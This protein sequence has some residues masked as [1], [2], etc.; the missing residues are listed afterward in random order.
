VEG[1]LRWF[2]DL[3]RCHSGSWDHPFPFVCCEDASEVRKEGGPKQAG[4]G[5]SPTPFLEALRKER[6]FVNAAPSFSPPN[7]SSWVHMFE[8]HDP[9]EGLQFDR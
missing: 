8:P 3:S 9:F 7:S 1:C 2:V 6:P 4:E 5:S